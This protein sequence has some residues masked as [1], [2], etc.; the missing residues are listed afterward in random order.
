M[1]LVTGYRALCPQVAGLYSVTVIR[2]NPSLSYKISTR[3][4]DCSFVSELL[5]GPWSVGN[6][7]CPFLVSL[8][9]S[10]ARGG[11]QRPACPAHLL[12]HIPSRLQPLSSGVKLTKK[13]E[14][15]PRGILQVQTARLVHLASRCLYSRPSMV[16]VTVL[17]RTEDS[18]LG[19]KT[20]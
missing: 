3:V 19:S 14:T 1:E 16:L 6:V 20:C 11:G 8:V 5:S 10:T 17:Q 7:A 9:K 18:L 15:S 12:S 13:G 2:T 4:N